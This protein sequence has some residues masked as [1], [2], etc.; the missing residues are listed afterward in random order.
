MAWLDMTITLIGCIPLVGDALKTSF[1]LL[2]SG[3][4]LPRILDAAS[5]ALRGNIDRWFREIDWGQVS[6]SV[7][8]SFDGV[9]RAF[10]DGLD[11]WIVKTVL[12]RKEVNLLIAQM[13]DLAQRAPKMLDEAIDEL[14]QLWGKALSDATP[15]STAVAM[16][17]R[18]SA[19]PPP[20]TTTRKV[21]PVKKDRSD[22]TP[23]TPDKPKT[24]ERR[25]SKS[26]KRASLPVLAEHLTDYWAARTRPNLKKANNHGRLW[27]E[28]D[29]EGR[30]GIDHLWM[31]A[32]N[33]TRPGIVADTK[34]SVFGEFRFLAAL[35]GDIRSQLEQLGKTEADSPTPGGQPN[36]FHS[37][38]RD[39]VDPGKV[40]VEGT[41][42]NEKALKRRLE[43]SS[44]GTQMSHQWISY[45]IRHEKLTARGL[46][47]VPLVK[48]YRKRKDLG[49]T[50]SPPYGRWIVLVTGRQKHLHEKK[51]GHQHQI[52][53]PLI[54]LP[55]GILD[56]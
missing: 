33:T 6:G 34:S 55:D 52:Q 12:G 30:H 44:K 50:A 45:W 35:P 43:E 56:K 48:S 23:T 28:W 41:G 25:A 20:T 46:Q 3:A 1:R 15:K 9:M 27:E 14:R 7:K 51:Q 10:I 22:G 26:T 53:Q 32:G 11:G 47:L 38:G 21:E 42:D 19:L 49:L 18:P 36:I 4:S 29:K 8:Q 17:P 37:E 2:R 24:D 16:G 54:T 39:K 31:Q 40:R 5:P 13:K